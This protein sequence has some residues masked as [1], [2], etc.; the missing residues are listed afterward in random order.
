M[1][2]KLVDLDEGTLVQYLG[3]YV[4]NWR[5]EWGDPSVGFVVD[6]DL[7][8]AVQCESCKYCDVLKNVN[9]DD[10]EDAKCLN[11]LSPCFK[12]SVFADFGCLLG[13]TYDE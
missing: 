11:S 5:Q 4:L 3:V 8:E 9:G 7:Y 2:Y 13:E 6:N 12:R 1:G 10:W